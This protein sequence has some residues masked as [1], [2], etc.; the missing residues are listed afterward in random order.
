MTFSP[1]D[2]VVERACN[3]QV[4]DKFINR[5]RILTIT[6]VSGW[7]VCWEDHFAGDEK[8]RSKRCTKRSYRVKV[9]GAFANKCTFV[10][11]EEQAA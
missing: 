2:K 11:V 5:F 1:G 6:R 4:G 9:L 10:P 3:P 7:Y 8:P